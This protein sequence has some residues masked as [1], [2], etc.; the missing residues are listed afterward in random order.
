MEATATTTSKVNSPWAPSRD[1]V[2]ET[3]SVDTIQEQVKAIWSSKSNKTESPSQN[4][5]EGIAND[6]AAVPFT[7]PEPKHDESSSQTPPVVNAPSRMSSRDVARAFQQVPNSTANP[8][9]STKVNSSLS[10]HQAPRQA[11]PH[12]MPPGIRAYPGYPSPMMSSPSPTLYPPG[13]ATSPVPRPMVASSPHYPPP[14]WVAMPPPPNG[15]PG[16]MRTVASPYGPQLMP[17][18]P[19]GAMPIYAPPPPGMQSNGP[20]QPNNVQHRPPGMPMMSPVPPQAQPAHHPMYATSP[21]MMPAMPHMPPPGTPYS[22]PVTQ[23][24][25]PEQSRGAYNGMMQQSPSFGPQPGP[26]ST[27]AVPPN[28]VRTPW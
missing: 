12:I 22:G 17:Y 28:Y 8:S 20:P 4:L 15:P 5:L 27:Y 19:P 1:L 10:S 6:M 25:A 21:V 11:A 2:K 18:P 3:P 13:M 23:G 7:V 16:M 14:M 26:P 24:R 9:S